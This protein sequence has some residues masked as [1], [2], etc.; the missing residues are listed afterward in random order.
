M[1][2]Q[3]IRD[4]RFAGVGS[5]TAILLSLVLGT[6]GVILLLSMLD[7]VAAVSAPKE[8]NT[9]ANPESTAS[10]AMASPNTSTVLITKTVAP[11][12]LTTGEA[13]EI[14]FN[15]P[16]HQKVDVVLAQDVSGSMDDPIGA[17]ETQT[18]LEASKAA[19][20]AFVDILQDVDRA[21]V[22]PYSTT[23]H[24]DQI[25]PLTTT[26]SEITRMINDLVAEGYTNVGEGIRVSHM[27]LITP[28]H[29]ASGAVK[30]IVLL[31]D[32]NANRPEGEAEEYALGQAEDAATDNIRIYTIGFGDDANAELLETIAITTGGKYY[33]TSHSSNLTDIYLAI[34][35]ELHNL[36]ITDILTPG[37]KTDCS[38]WPNDWCIS[39]PSG[40][41]TVTWPI[42]DD[43]LIHSPLTLCITATVNL[44]P[45]YVGPI[46]SPNSRFCYQIADGQTKCKKLNNPT[47]TVTARKIYLPLIMR[48]YPPPIVTNGGFE[49]DGEAKGPDEEWIGW[50]HGGKLNQSITSTNPHSGNFSA[51]LGNPAYKCRNGVPIGSAWLEQTVLVPSTASP[52]LSFW[53]NILTHD[54]NLVLS[55][56]YDSF[57]VKINGSRVF[58][59]MN[60]TESYGCNDLRDLEW[61]P[62]IIDLSS[63]AGMFIT[64]RFENWNRLD[65]WYNTWTY[66]DDVE[67]LR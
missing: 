41:T 9:P 61:R 40:V 59:Y 51:L 55:D 37:V 5:L 6:L 26:Q 12:Q 58:L 45:N 30:A 3:C 2:T 50:T 52:E 18:R 34:A 1:S 4:S 46:N 49:D 15:G 65:N 33:S 24:L 62:K 56:T 20:C 67:V 29:D 23:V 31:S 36:V 57:E 38:T 35:L 54:T 7:T 27:E 8:S 32:G 53:Y 42:S 48:N 60:S 39:D 28:P 63:Y 47:I 11:S 22:V 43:L 44:T 13:V 64:I 14:C 17:G 10:V 19:A 21:A 25:Q 66:V 16:G